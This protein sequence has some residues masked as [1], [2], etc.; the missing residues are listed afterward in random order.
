MFQRK[1][2]GMKYWDGNSN[3]GAALEATNAVFE[4]SNRYND[5]NTSKVLI[6]LTDGR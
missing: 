6:V 1:V 2:Y 5:Q 4:S 3:T